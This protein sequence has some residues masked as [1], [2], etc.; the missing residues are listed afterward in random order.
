[1]GVRKS[2]AG[3]GRLRPAGIGAAGDDAEIAARLVECGGV[4]VGF[5]GGRLNVAHLLGAECERVLKKSL[6]ALAALG[7]LCCFMVREASFCYCYQLRALS[8]LPGA[9]QRYRLGVV[10]S[11]CVSPFKAADAFMISPSV[12]MTDLMT[13]EDARR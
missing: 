12:A 3:R 4:D 10:F 11:L 6:R 5:F 8:L 1:M 2:L 13:H 7:R 9:A